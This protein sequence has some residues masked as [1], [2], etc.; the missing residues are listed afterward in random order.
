MPRFSSLLASILLVASATASFGDLSYVTS[1]GT[2]LIHITNGAAGNHYTQWS[3][4]ALGRQQG[5]V[6]VGRQADSKPPYTDRDYCVCVGANY[7]RDDARSD[8]FALCAD[9]GALA[10]PS[11]STKAFW[12]G[13]CRTPIGDWNW[14]DGNSVT[15]VEGGVALHSAAP[16]EPG[17]WK[18]S[19]GTVTINWP[20]WSSIDTPALSSDGAQLTGTYGTTKKDP[21]ATHT[22]TRTSPCI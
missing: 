3:R 10:G 5:C 7:G 11:E 20:H 13:S 2:C 18:Q 15:F 14:F 19:G 21:G 16:R 4:G 6:R 8:G 12:C 1:A 17:T 9:R 22:S